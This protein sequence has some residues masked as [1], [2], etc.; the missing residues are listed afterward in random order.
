MTKIGCPKVLKEVEANQNK[1]FLY[2]L[3]V[4]SIFHISILVSGGPA[5][6]GYVF[7]RRYL[8]RMTFPTTKLCWTHQKVWCKMEMDLK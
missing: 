8:Q 6:K 3:S 4:T 7:L 1:I 2:T 5:V